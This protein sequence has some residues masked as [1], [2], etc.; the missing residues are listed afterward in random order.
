MKPERQAAV[1]EVLQSG[2]AKTV[3][4]AEALLSKAANLEPATPLLLPNL[5]DDGL[6]HCAVADLSSRVSAE[7]V[8]CIITDPPYQ[9]SDLS[10]YS[11]LAAFAAH[12]LRP[13]GSLVAMV[14]KAY[15]LDV[16]MRLN[17]EP[18]R[19]AWEF[20]YYLPGHNVRMWNERIC[21]A[22]KPLL[23]FTKGER[24]GP[25]LNDVISADVF[26][27]AG[28]D[29]AHHAWGQPVADMEAII[30][31]FT[32]PGHVI[33]DPFLGGGATA[34]AA[35]LCGRPFVG[36]DIEARCVERTRE[37]LRQEVDGGAA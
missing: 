33:C 28:E 34:V 4:Q 17:L 1:R 7:S 3:R 19:Y 27:G 12:A 6:Y 2:E 29:K 25:W 37:R 32:R 15:L 10:V 31:H 16:A 21:S 26:V 35:K 8:D 22:W 5:A 30:E 18:L 20:A 11:D 14:G 13:G 24:N 23:L 9:L 36:C